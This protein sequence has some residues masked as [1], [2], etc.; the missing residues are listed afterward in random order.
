MSQNTQTISTNH[1]GLPGRA[2]QGDRPA[3]VKCQICGSVTIPGVD[4]GNQPVGDLILSTSQ[5]NQPETYYPL[6]LQHCMNCGLT[7]LSYIVNPKVVYKNFPFVSGT[8]RTA[9][10]HLQSLPTQLVKMAGLNGKSFA[11]DIGSNDGTLLKGYIPYNVKFLG[12]DPSGDPVRI[13]NEQGIETMHAFFNVETAEYV[14]EHYRRADAITACGVFGHIADLAGVMKGV[15]RLLAKRGVF[16]TDSQYWLDTMQRLHY[17]NMFHQHLRYYSMKPLI[18]LFRQ[19]DMDVFDVERSEVY[20]GSIRVFSCHA[21]DYPISNRVTKLLALEEKERLYDEATYEAFS[22]KVEER[23]RKLFEEVY[24]LTSKGNKVIGIG[25]PAKASTICNYCR[26]GSDLVDYITEV[27][28]LRIGKYL[29]GVHIPII[30]EDYMFED[31]QPA[32]AGILFAW[33]YYD[34]I[35]PKLRKRGFKGRIL[36]P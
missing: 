8:T 36:Q 12:V 13:A 26:L 2:R 21:G 1:A 4:L 32:D 28:P 23:R 34:E 22:F 10:R 27:N 20:G 3:Q 7:Q 9:T 11:V 29:P 5:L 6:K 24:S 16:A 18:H 33:N 17:D 31:L 19:Y 15:K 30:S 35:V 25:A 14:R